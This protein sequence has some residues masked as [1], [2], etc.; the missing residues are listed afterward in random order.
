M[1]FVQD[2]FPLDH[3]VHQKSQT[4]IRTRTRS[5][6]SALRHHTISWETVVFVVLNRNAGV[7]VYSTGS[8]AKTSSLNLVVFLVLVVSSV[9]MHRIVTLICND[10]NNAFLECDGS[11]QTCH[12]DVGSFCEQHPS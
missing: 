4:M 1:P 2:T 10:W 8:L 3:D 6:L 11:F 7:A 12:S 9:N 5:V